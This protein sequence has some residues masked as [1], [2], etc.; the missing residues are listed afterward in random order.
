MR[1]RPNRRAW[2]AR[3][4]QASVGSNRIPSARPHLSFR[5]VGISRHSLARGWSSASGPRH[6]RQKRVSFL[7]DCAGGSRE[8]RGHASRRCSGYVLLVYETPRAGHPHRHKTLV[9]CLVLARVGVWRGD[10]VLTPDRD[11]AM[12][13]HVKASR[14]RRPRS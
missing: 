7:R 8:F 4:P 13:R 14:I 11:E 10:G 1:E 5:T 9:H 2:R 6:A 3:E 12:C